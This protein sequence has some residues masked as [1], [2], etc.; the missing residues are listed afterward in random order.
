MGPAAARAA[1]VRGAAAAQGA[2]LGLALAAPH[3]Q[4]PE[5]RDSE[6]DAPTAARAAGVGFELCRAARPVEACARRDALP[7][8]AR[9]HGVHR[10]DAWLLCRPDA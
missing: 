1:A 3:R 8:R 2:A 10:D 9:R 4:L 5:R 7:R 6:R